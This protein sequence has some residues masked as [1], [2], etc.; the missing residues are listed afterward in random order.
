MWNQ[1]GNE[2]PSKKYGQDFRSDFDM[3]LFHLGE[4]IEILHRYA[5]FVNSLSIPCK[6]YYG[7]PFYILFKTFINK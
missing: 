3:F 4:I 2:L 5:I 7:E 1:L 6:Y